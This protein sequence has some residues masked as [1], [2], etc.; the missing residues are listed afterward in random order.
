[1]NAFE[2][3]IKEF[4]SKKKFSVSSEE[5]NAVVAKTSRKCSFIH[6]NLFPEIKEFSDS[7]MKCGSNILGKDKKVCAD[8]KK[9]GYYCRMDQWINDNVNGNLIYQLFFHLRKEKSS[10]FKSYDTDES[11]DNAYDN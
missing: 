10:G 11:F 3:L 9:W 8:V 6:N 7:L 1:M 4:S 5:N 2:K